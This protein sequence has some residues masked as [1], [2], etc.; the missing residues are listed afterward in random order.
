MRNNIGLVIN[1]GVVALSVLAAC[2]S[3][4][5]SNGNSGGAGTGGG[6]AGGSGGTAAA[7]A[8]GGTTPVIGG[9]AGVGGASA[10]SSG[11]GGSGAV[12][13]ASAGSGGV[14]NAGSGGATVDDGDWIAP[15]TAAMAAVPPMGWNSWNKFAC[16]VSESL[17]KGVADLMVTNGMKDAGYQYVNIDDCWQSSR[18]GDTIVADATDFPSGMKSLADYVHG[19]GLKLG[20]YSDRG[21]QTCAGRPGSQGYE[22][23]DAK[24]YASW[25]VDYLKYDNCNATLDAATQYRTM[26]NALAGSGRAI[27]FSICAWSFVDYM[28]STGQLWRTTADINTAWSSILSNMDANALLAAYARPGAWNDPDML[29]VGNGTLSDAENRAHFSLWS[30]MAAPLIAGND[31]SAMTKTQLDML[32]NRDVIAVDQDPWGY[33]GYRVQGDGGLEVWVRPLKGVGQRAVL[34]FNRGD[35]AAPITAKWA[36]AGLAP[37]KAHVTNL[38]S[39]QDLGDVTDQFSASVPSHDVVMLRISGTEPPAPHGMVNLSDLTASYAA[40]GWGPVARN[41]SVGELADQDGKALTINGV[42]YAQ[43]LGVHAASLLRYRLGGRCSHFTADIGL[44][45][46][47]TAAGGSAVFEVLVDGTVKSQSA[48]LNHGTHVSVDVD[49][50][51][52]RELKLLVTDGGDGNSGDHAD[53]ANARLVCAD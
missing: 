33:Q 34:L 20:V 35:A 51:G 50:S 49:V 30:I 6:G 23:A 18:N 46:E 27:V 28:P 8:N 16:N 39:H 4:S 43:G 10:G 13:G 3:S 45:D 9:G 42:S 14:A 5:S 32:T 31:L 22:V 44:D 41:K 29:E 40:N 25:G 36:D 26:S 21:T 2:T 47:S 1:A 38:W 11:S 53:W 17:I 7:G 19:K 52:G 12:G 37:G 48:V 15:P 24:T